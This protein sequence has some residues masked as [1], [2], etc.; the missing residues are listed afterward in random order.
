[1]TLDGSVLANDSRLVRRR[2][3]TLVRPDQRRKTWP[4]CLANLKTFAGSASLR[5]LEECGNL[6]V[7]AE[8]SD[9]PG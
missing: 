4:T 2:P 3:W 5:Y 6:V 7:A 8:A 1:M 9:C